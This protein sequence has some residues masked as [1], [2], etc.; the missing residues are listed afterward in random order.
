M[1]PLAARLA[2]VLALCAACAGPRAGEVA[3]RRTDRN[4]LTQEQLLERGFRNAL[5]AVQALR[6]N[7]LLAKGTDSFASPTQVLVYQDGS[8]IGGVESLRWIPTSDIDHIRYYDGVD[9]AARWGLDHGQGVI[10]VA[11]QSGSGAR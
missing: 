10:F 1:R 2:L 7:W 11:S 6:A 5:E 3:P 4:L 8:R 9:A